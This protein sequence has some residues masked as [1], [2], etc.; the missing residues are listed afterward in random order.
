MALR[1]YNTLTR[2]KEEFRP[3]RE[4]RVGIYFC[5]MTVQDRPHVGHMRAF[6]TGD[7]VRRYLEFK[8]YDVFYLTNFTDI[9]DK[10]IMKSKDEGIDWR[11]LAERNIEE[12]FKAANLMNLKPATHYPRATNHIQEIIEMVEAIMANGFAYESNGN[13]Y[14][15][16]EKFAGYGKLS[17]KKLKD[18]IAGARVEPDPNKRH[19][20]D[21]ALW[22]AHKPGE[23]YWHSPWGKGRPGWH[24][25]CSAMSTHYLGQPFDIHG[26]GTD[27][28][29]PH[30]ENEIAQAEAARGVKFVNFWIHNE[31]LNLKGEK[32]S[33]STGLF[34]AIID[35]LEHYDPNAVRLYLLKS[36]YRSPIDYSEERLNEAQSAWSNFVEFFSKLPKELPEINLS[37]P[38][39][40]KWV[41]AFEDAMDDDFNTPK[42]LAVAFELLS[43]ANRLFTAGDETFAAHA[44]L[45]KM[46]LEVLGFRV[47]TGAQA[48]GQFVDDLLELIVEVRSELRKERRYDLADK[49]RDRL[50]SLGVL[51]EDTPKG[52]IWKL[53]GRR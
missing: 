33:K 2:T 19:P 32:M 12:F 38:S 22:K 51:L 25:E 6:I 43:E 21:F 8:G 1:I 4:G 30:H 24:I 28:I 7:I 34:F 31:M 27:L 15:E 45:L 18:L 35:V 44:A 37:D 46:L 9:D 29:F 3:V 10:I 53:S 26:G 5:G 23:P 20:A 13:V 48:L 16:V 50:G 52:T 42:A 36:H 14:F 11:M 49:I 39:L 40:A 17:G 41:K 47:E